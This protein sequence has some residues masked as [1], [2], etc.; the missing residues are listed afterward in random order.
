MGAAGGGPMQGPSAR[1]SGMRSPRRRGEQLDLL[2]EEQRAELQGEVLDEVLVGEYR[3]LVRAPVGIVI[4]LPEV[5]ELVDHARVGLEV[6]D[7]LLVLAALLERRIAEFAV[8]LDR[9]PHLADVQGVG[10]HL[11]D[12]HGDPPEWLMSQVWRAGAGPSRQVTG[13]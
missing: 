6:S 13:E 4:E 3:S 10:P 12:R 9:L 7:Q 11:I 5:D 8:Q 2:G 1:C